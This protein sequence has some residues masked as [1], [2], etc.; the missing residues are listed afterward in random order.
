MRCSAAPLVWS[1]RSYQG[2]HAPSSERCFLRREATK[3]VYQAGQR[4]KTSQSVEY[5][6]DLL[7][8]VLV[9]RTVETHPLHHLVGPASG[10]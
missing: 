7:Y 9:K 1:D 8:L 3:C 2:K 6:G 10:S 4:K 5:S